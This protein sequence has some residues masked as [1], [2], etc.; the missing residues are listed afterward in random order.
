MSE[1]TPG[2]LACRPTVNDDDEPRDC[3]IAREFGNLT[4]ADDIGDADASRLVACWNACIGINPEAVPELL[5]ALEVVTGLLLRL[6]ECLTGTEY[7]DTGPLD[8][9]LAAIKKAK[10]E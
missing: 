7:D 4:V 5:A 9:A 10:G 8:N 2:R 6:Y 1:Y 3:L